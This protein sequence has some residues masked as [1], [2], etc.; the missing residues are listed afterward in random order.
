MLDK[1]RSFN[2][3]LYDYGYILVLVGCVVFFFVSVFM[4]HNTLDFLKVELLRAAV[5]ILEQQLI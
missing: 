5:K 1:L 2:R 3:F 4:V